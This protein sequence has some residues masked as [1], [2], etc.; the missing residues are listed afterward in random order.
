M[1]FQTARVPYATVEVRQQREILKLLQRRNED[2][3]V[4]QF[5]AQN[6]DSGSVRLFCDL[7]MFQLGHVP[8]SVKRG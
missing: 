6:V 3:L 5:V 4:P 2:A 1:T 7:Y 8:G